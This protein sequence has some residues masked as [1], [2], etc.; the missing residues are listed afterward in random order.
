MSDLRGK[1]ETVEHLIE[2]M[3]AGKATISIKNTK[4]GNH[5][6]FKVKKP[7]DNPDYKYP[8]PHMVSVLTGPNNDDWKNYTYIG[9]I[10][11]GDLKTFRR[12]KKSRI[13]SEALSVKAFTWLCMFLTTKAALPKTV[14][15]WHEG[16]C[17]RCGRKLTVPESVE[18]G[19]GPECAGLVG[20]NHN[21]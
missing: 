6:T 20:H 7:K 12:G 19:L 17:G 21:H 5:F 8:S 10:I 15:V 18:R 1:F 16:I 9:T 2:Y 3:M 11:K 4:T 13:S 14:E